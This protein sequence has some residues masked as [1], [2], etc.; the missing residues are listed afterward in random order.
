MNTSDN[1]QMNQKIKDLREHFDDVKTYKTVQNIPNRS[2]IK[3]IQRDNE[4]HQYI[5]TTRTAY[6]RTFKHTQKIKKKNLKK[7]F[8][9]I[10]RIQTEN[11]NPFIEYLLYK[12]PKKDGDICIFPSTTPTKKTIQDEIQEMMINTLQYGELKWAF[13]GY[14]E[15]NNNVY[16]FIKLTGEKEKLFSQRVLMRDTR[17]WWCIIDEICNTRH[18]LNFPIHEIVT[19]LFYN[20]PILIYLRNTQGY[21]L[22]IPRSLYYGTYAQLLPFYFVFGPKLSVRGRYGPYYY[23]GVYNKAIRYGGWSYD[24][25]KQTH[26]DNNITDDNGKIIK[27]GIVR[28]AVFLGKIKVLLNHP[29]D[30][31]D[32]ILEENYQKKFDFQ[33]RLED[34]E[35]QW[36]KHYDSLYYG[37]AKINNSNMLWRLNPGYVTKNF[38][39]QIPLTMH[40]IDKKTLP[41]NW[42]PLSD[43]YYI[44]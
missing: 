21:N 42:N 23:L 6:L 11:D 19:N 40:I 31:K 9:A 14:I 22:P 38:N 29:Q 28:F 34:R 20:N 43:K 13:K 4:Y 36:A 2:N 8:F 15:A 12:Y 10:Y 24:Y 39:Q 3:K 17:W 26:A 37:R 18:I 32:N 30:R 44:E 33:L 25:R 7:I 1:L 27:G 41:L 35:G 5:G 16:L